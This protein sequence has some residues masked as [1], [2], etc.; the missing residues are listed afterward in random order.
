MHTLNQNYIL[1][2]YN[3]KFEDYTNK[4]KVLNTLDDY[5]NNK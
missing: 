2:K 4:D 3:F 5:Y 1:S